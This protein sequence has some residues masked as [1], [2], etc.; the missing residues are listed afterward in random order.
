MRIS[1]IAVYCGTGAGN[2]RAYIQAAHDLAQ[3]FAENGIRGVYGGGSLGLMGAFATAMISH[4]GFV[5]GII[6]R[7]VVDLEQA[8]TSVQEY[9]LV[10]SM[11]E[12][13]K[14]FRTKEQ[15]SL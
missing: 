4:G 9:I 6:P 10:D 15:L 14:M 2:D 11:A 3:A 1:A 8:I 7:H 12:R 5:T 13:K